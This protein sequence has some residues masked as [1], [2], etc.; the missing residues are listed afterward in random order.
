VRSDKY[1]VPIH[2]TTTQTTETSSVGRPIHKTDKQQKEVAGMAYTLWRIGDGG[3]SH[4]NDNNKC[5]TSAVL[6][7]NSYLYLLAFVE[8]CGTKNTDI[9]F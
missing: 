6:P 2:K 9:S 8:I 3:V 7:P 4:N 1:E 5:L